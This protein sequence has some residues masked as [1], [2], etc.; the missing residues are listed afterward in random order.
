MSAA[1]LA[2]LEIRGEAFVTLAA[3]AECYRVE[4][5]WIE[6]VYAEGLLGVG[7]RVGGSIALPAAGLDRLAAILRWHRHHGLDLDALHAL[8]DD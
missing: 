8:L 3:A 2:Y 7:E 1:Q 5:R 6:L 4:V